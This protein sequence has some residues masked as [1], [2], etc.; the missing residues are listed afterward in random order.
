MQFGYAG[1]LRDTLS[2]SSLLGDSRNY[3]HIRGTEGMVTV[4][5]DR[6]IV[7]HD[8]GATRTV[9]LPDEDV[10]VQMWRTLA[11]CIAEKREPEYAKECALR[12]LSILFAVERA[13][14]TGE[15]APLG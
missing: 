5:D 13:I 6:L 8:D 14:K 12:D 11:E 2:Y 7:T 10:H 9:E 3:F 1:R 15:K 4:E